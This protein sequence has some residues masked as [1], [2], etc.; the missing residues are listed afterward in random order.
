MSRAERAR[1]LA[2]A[3]TRQPSVTGTPDA[4][5]FGPWLAAEVSRA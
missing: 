1:R 5:S 3:L 2:L 4:V